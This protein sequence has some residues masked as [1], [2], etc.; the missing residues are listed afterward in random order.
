MNIFKMTDIVYTNGN[1]NGLTKKIFT[2][3]DIERNK[4]HQEAFSTS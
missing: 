1:V 3:L 2:I 4:K